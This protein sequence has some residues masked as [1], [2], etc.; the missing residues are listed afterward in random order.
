MLSDDVLVE[1]FKVY[2]DELPWWAPPN[3][4][5]I[6]VHVCCRWRYLVLGSPRHLNLRLEYTGHGHMLEV[7]DAWPV[8]PVILKSN[9]ILPNGFPHPKSDQQWDNILAALESEHYNR[10]REIEIYVGTTSRWDRF[11]AAMQKPF[12]ELTCLRVMALDDGVVPVLPDSLLGGSA[13]RL[14]ELK[15]GRIPFPSMPKLLLSVK[16]ASLHSPFGTSLI[17]AFHPT[18][19]PLP[20][21]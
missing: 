16:M 2:I 19:W 6:L 13:P 10:I 12:P 15:L 20:S 14:R 8:L 9:D 21:Q 7:L 11:A 3:V 5:Q 18:R 1:I 17:L 4:W